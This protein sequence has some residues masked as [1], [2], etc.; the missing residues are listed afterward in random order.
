MTFFF[1]LS[2]LCWCRVLYSIISFYLNSYY[3]KKLLNYGF[4][5]QLRELS[6]ILLMSLTVAVLGLVISWLISN[7]IIA[8]VVSL[9]ICPVVYVTMCRKLKVSAYD[10]LLE[11]VK[12]KL[13][14]FRKG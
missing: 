3:T 2:L 1:D 8:L 13:H 6:P 9:I 4:W 11:I 14:G 12:D 10:E 7:A 5:S